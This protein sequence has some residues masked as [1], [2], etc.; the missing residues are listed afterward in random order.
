[1]NRQ[2]QQPVPE[3]MYRVLPSLTSL[4]QQMMT[5]GSNDRSA[6]VEVNGRRSRVIQ[7]LQRKGPDRCIGLPVD[8]Q[9]ASDALE[10]AV[11]HFKEPIRF[12][13]NVWAVAELHKDPIGIPPILLVGEPGIGKSYF[14]DLLATTLGTEQGRVDFDNP[15]AG[16]QL[17]GSDKHW[18]NS[19]SG[20]LFSLVCEG[21]Y[22]NPVVLLEE[23][24]KCGFGAS[25]DAPHPLTQLH[26][27]L[28]PQSARRLIDVSLDIEFD[29]SLVTYVATANSLEGLEAPLRS[30]FEIFHLPSPSP[31]QAYEIACQIVGS[32]L[33]RLKP[34]HGI[35]FDRS[36]LHVLSQLTP[37]LI[38]RLA[39][40][41]TASAKVHGIRSIQ[42]DHILD[43]LSGTEPVW[44][45]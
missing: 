28:E 37:R 1:M 41:A 44:T 30:R 32:T 29:A 14:A 26:S 17:R 34:D 16:S 43:H 21:A 15:S 33:A 35:A 10:R 36:A 7:R 9:A 8:W 27:V 31:A 4:S 38:R 19:S 22:A 24:D 23:L 5:S 25:R 39:F 11:P 3:G 40:T 20:L 6:D 2:D 18:G 45:H 13:R 42:A 12:I